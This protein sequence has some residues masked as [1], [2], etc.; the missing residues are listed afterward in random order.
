MPYK[1]ACPFSFSP[2]SIQIKELAMALKAPKSEKAEKT[3]AREALAAEKTDLKQI[4]KQL[5]E[6]RPKNSVN[7]QDI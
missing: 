3:V 1:C 7:S 2:H 4:A 6:K 5:L